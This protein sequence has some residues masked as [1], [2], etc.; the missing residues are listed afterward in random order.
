MFYGQN[1]ETLTAE[2]A[3]G[4]GP[5][6]RPIGCIPR[7]RMYCWLS[8]FILT[9]GEAKAA[10]MSSPKGHTHCSVFTLEDVGQ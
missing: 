1:F 6:N 7:R 9:V 3:W 5:Q 2:K 8:A 10:I 4:M